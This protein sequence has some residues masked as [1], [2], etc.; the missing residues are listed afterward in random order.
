MALSGVDDR[1]ARYP[2]RVQQLAIGG[3]GGAKQGHIVA[4]HGA[5]AAGLKKI[6]LHVDDD[7]RTPIRQ[8]GEG[9]R[10]GANLHYG[11]SR[12]IVAFPMQSACRC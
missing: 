3:N 10:L 2:P 6:P 7:E 8:E 4:E 9:I 5:E 1:Q 11:S 12:A